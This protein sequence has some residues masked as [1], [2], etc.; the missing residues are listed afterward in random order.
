MFD[1]L[2]RRRAVRRGLVDIGQARGA[3]VLH[4]I[5]AGWERRLAMRNANPQ[6]GEVEMTMHLREGMVCAVNERIVRSSK[7]I[8][9]L[10]GTESWGSASSIRPS[11]LTDISIHLRDVREKCGEHDPHAI[12]ECKRIAGNDAGLCREYVIE[13]I[14]RF[15]TGKYGERHAVAF[16]V[17]YLLSADAETAA[18]GTNRYLSS[19]GRKRD[20]L[21]SCTILDEPWARSSH[22]VRQS[23]AGPIGLHHAFLDFQQP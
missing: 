17:G 18:S 12:I 22:H 19:K 13:G 1:R 16:M 15:I 21:G 2:R 11:G 3:D 7:K 8:T 9:V 4:I 23:S 20:H 14:D 10:P 5:K 6:Q